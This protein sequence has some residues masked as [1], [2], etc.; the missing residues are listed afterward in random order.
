MWIIFFFSFLLIFFLFSS[1][2]RAC[3]Q[4]GAAIVFVFSGQCLYGGLLYFGINKRYRPCT[5]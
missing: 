2:N 5:L 1:R 3:A 4:R